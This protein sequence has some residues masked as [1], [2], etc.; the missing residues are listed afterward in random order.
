MPLA[1]RMLLLAA[2]AVSSG[3]AA[4]QVACQKLPAPRMATD[5]SG[6]LYVAMTAAELERLIIRVSDE[7]SGKC[8]ATEGAV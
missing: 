1:I 4:K 3:C 2:V 7:A 8:V 6:T 5:S